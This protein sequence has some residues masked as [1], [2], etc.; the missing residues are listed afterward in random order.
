MPA[1][2]GLL[3]VWGIGPETA[4]SILLYAYGIPEFVVD[5]Y[6]RRILIS[7]NIIREQ[8]TYGEIKALLERELRKDYCIYQECH[9]LLV[10][11]AKRCYARSQY[12]EDALLKGLSSGEECTKK[13]RCHRYI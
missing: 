7:K 4:D 9:A 6:T 11:H 12:G 2:D 8:A 13:P 10:E 1:R 5:A 3:K